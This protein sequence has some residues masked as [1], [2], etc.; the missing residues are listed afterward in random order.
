MAGIFQ[1][2][3][4]VANA[5][6]RTGKWI[7]Y[8]LAAL[9]ILIA[10]LAASIR[11]A[12]F[13]SE[14]YS[15]QL[16]SLVSSYV[17]S[18]VEIGEVDL[19]WNRF[20]ANASLRDVQIRSADGAETLIELPRIE[21]ELNVR[22]VLLERR[23]SV[24]NVQLSD[25][26]LVASYEG[27]GQLQMFGRRLS[28]K[29]SS[30]VQAESLDSNSESQNG[31]ELLNARESQDASDA[32]DKTARNHS[33]LNWLFNAERISILDSEI[34][35]VDAKRDRE[36]KVDNVNIRAFNDGDDH[37]IRISSA[38]PG[39]IGEN[40]LASFDFTGKAANVSEW[41]GQFY[42]NTKALH[43]DEL[44]EVWRT[45][46]QEYAGFADVQLWGAWS[47]TRV[48]KVRV[49]ASVSDFALQQPSSS[50]AFSTNL[51]A[52]KVDVD[53]DWVRLNSGWQLT[54]NQLAGMLDDRELALDGLEMQVARE[55]RETYFS[56]A[57]P[58]IDLQS[59]KPVYSFAD[60]MLPNDLPFRTLALR[61]GFLSDWRA[62]GITTDE[63]TTLTELRA[64]VVDLT[65]DPFD[66]TPGISDLTA[67]V[68][69]ED[70]AGRVTIDSQDISL[71]LPQLYDTPLPGVNVDGEIRFLVNTDVADTAQPEGAADN[72]TLTPALK[73][74]AVT[75][76][77]RVV[78]LD[79]ETSTV[80]SISGHADG[81]H[82][83]DSHTSILNANIARLKDFYPVRKLKPKLLN[84]LQAA[85]LGGDVVRGR[86]EVKGNLNDFSPAE[87]RGHFYAEADLVD[88]TLKFRP[89]WPAV[90]EVDGNLSFSSSSMRGRVYQGSI[91]QARFSDARLFL[92][93]FKQPVIEVQANAIGPL[94][95]MLDFA[96]TGPLAPKIGKV[97]GNATGAGTSRFALDLKVP[98][99][100]E[101][102]DELVVDGEAHLDNAQIS[103]STYGIDLESATGKL[104]FNRRGITV[105]NM[106]VRYQGLPLSVNAIQES[107]SK[108]HFNRI[109]INGPVAV[110]SVMQ[111]YG[112]PLVDQFKGT[113]NWNIDIDVTRPINSKKSRVELTATSD[114]SGTAL[115][116][117][118]PMNKGADELRE[119]RVY[120]DFAS[121]EKDWWVELPGLMKSRIRTGNDK[122][123]ESMAVVLGSSENSVLPWRGIS[124]Q[125]D[126]H[127]LDASGWL[128][129]SMSLKEQQKDAGEGFPLFAKIS[130]GQM[131]IGDQV[132]DDLVYIA[133]RDGVNQV[134]RV[135]S[136][137]FSGELTLQPD[138]GVL[139]PLVLRLDRLDK[140]L[141]VAIAASQKS[142]SESREVTGQLIDP[143]GIPPLDIRVSELIWDNWRFS[144]V[145]LRSEPTDQGLQITALTAR[146]NSM[147][148]SGRGSW[149]QFNDAGVVSHKTLL[150]LTASFDDVGRAMAEIA[151]VKS[152][153]EGSGEAALSL[154][155]PT[156]AYAPDLKQLQGQLLFN[157]RDGRILSVQPG[158]GRILGLFALQ[159]LPRRLTF[160]FRDITSTGLEY[161]G[162]SGNLSIANGQAQ[163]NAIAM[164]G[165]V[166]EILIH[167]STGF[168]DKTYDQKIDVLPRVSGALP[169][170][171][172]LSGGP[173][174]G[175]TALLA[176]GVL[177]GIGVN[178]DE[179][180]RRRYSLTG[181]WD[182]PVWK[183]VNVANRSASSR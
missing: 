165:P 68:V 143:R 106:Q 133:Y 103:S 42:L 59:L 151:D 145:A 92:P 95:D 61:R 54:F 119:A 111:S 180:G 82:M 75:E 137:L 172:V 40:S 135:E 16:A 142:K 96:Q 83:I 144:N 63:T 88:A 19:V 99:K 149:T 162:V 122:K 156:P 13:Y 167:G 67:S 60:A 73:W 80:L 176:D 12:V 25:L 130:T 152:F 146:Q 155:W 23:L 2:S 91:R 163:T 38:L 104:K 134:H 157:L 9:I 81:S 108:N 97:F 153:A 35:V 47:G 15:E 136:S 154:T 3:N 20:D 34:T 127:R 177:K 78:S 161:S 147:R 50:G 17:G 159:S 58:D 55:A 129:L 62:S 120:R 76:D 173:A 132:F 70:G 41:D 128:Q 90:T 74:K 131:A 21:L 6:T 138:R 148:V 89:D 93:D 69:F 105:D 71:S 150:D 44:S 48:N 118:V 86:V 98:L 110:A 178:L 77:L 117:P 123:L 14:D 164:S 183:A 11:L 181:S 160:D 94:A 27:R 125:G 46:L 64:N 126:V 5:L 166:A 30:K 79:L 100:K 39:D 45:P 168:V 53:F 109:R 57:G 158:A 66:K 31:N 7:L 65:I 179:I 116:L 24:R 51:Q 56:I 26:S 175:V 124:I 171:G 141:L 107:N 113:S 101:L 84:W 32:T 33:V 115:D 43:L 121:Q 18:P 87:G 36:Y 139:E 85:P 10:L 52:E 8:L 112:I 170:L 114:L 182:D 174:A 29:G 49:I 37:K 22:D 28:R 169:L 1:N 102:R 140:R 4:M 72:E